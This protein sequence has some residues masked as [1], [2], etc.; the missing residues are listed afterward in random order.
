MFGRGECSRHGGGAVEF[1][2]RL[3][4]EN[5]FDF[6]ALIQALTRA[7]CGCQ[8]ASLYRGAPIKTL[9]FSSLRSFSTG[10]VLL[11]LLVS[12]PLSLGWCG[13]GGASAAGLAADSSGNG[14]SN[15]SDSE[16][17]Y[18]APAD[19]RLNI[20]PAMAINPLNGAFSSFFN[21][22]APPPFNCSGGSVAVGKFLYVSLPVGCQNQVSQ[23]AGYLVHPATGALTALDGSPFRLP[24][25]AIPGGLAT[26]PNSNLLYVA[27]ASGSIEVFKVDS[28]TGVPKAIRGSP[29][30]SGNN[31]QLV[32]DPSGNYLYASED[33][34]P[35]G[36]LAF[37]IST[38]GA[39]TP[40]PGSPFLLGGSTTFFNHQPFGIVDTGKYVYTA[41]GASNQIAGF[42]IDSETG[43]LT[44]VPGSVFPTGNGPGPLAW[45]GNFLYTVN[46]SD[47]TVS[48]YS[49]DPTNG[50]LTAVPGSP[51]G[52]DGALLTIDLSGKYLY[53]SEDR[54]I[55]GFNIDPTTGTLSQGL[56]SHD[57][58][59]AL[60]L[61]VVR[62]TPSPS[63]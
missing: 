45:T 10:L 28:A 16:F 12:F 1:Q 51:F 15:G 29:F 2:F 53:L 63:P 57:N 21:V 5:F 49:I 47:G 59:G 62:V 22:I 25:G 43:S 26:A 34:T 35:G 13:T 23:I 27:D 50:V 18:G 39:I 30:A 7:V 33:T 4:N 6:A 55:Q 44:P 14:T 8:T 19:D 37:S 46:Q 38:S 24:K 56:G 42:S 36:V 9:R 58:N 60:W 20:F 61:T 11:A 54:G 32:V 40:V 41:L 3:R 48:G 52:E 17:L 31:S